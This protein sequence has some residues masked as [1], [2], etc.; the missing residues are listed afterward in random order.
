[1]VKRIIGGL[2]LVVACGGLV[3]FSEEGAVL[4]VAFATSDI[5]DLHP[6]IAV[7]KGDRAIIHTMFNGL[8]RYKPGDISAGFEPDLAESWE[9][10]SDGKVWTFHLRKG[11]MF[12]PWTNPVTGV[13]HPPYELT[14]EDVVY[15]FQS[16]AD[17][18]R[19]AYAGEY[20]GLIFE[21]VGPYT[22][23]VLLPKP[24]SPTLIFPKVADYAGGLIISKKAAED[25]GDNYHIRPVGTGPFMF[26]EYKSKEKYVVVRNEQ[27]FRGV[28]KLAGVEFRFMP[29]ESSRKFGLMS[30]E[31]DVIVGASQPFIEEMRA[32]PGVVVDVYGPGHVTALFFN[33]TKKPLDDIRV[34]RAILYCLDRDEAR[35]TVGMDLTE[36]VYTLV[37]PVLPGG[38]TREELE[39][40]GQEDGKDYIY[41][42]DRNRAKE[43]LTEAGYPNG[44]TLDMYIT[45]RADY[46][47]YMPNIQAQLREIGIDLRLKVVEH[48][49]YHS[50]IR[51]DM[52]PIV[53]YNVWRPTADVFLTHF[54]HSD[55][56]V[57][58]GASPNINFSHIGGVDLDGDGV[59]DSVDDLI[60]R[61][62]EELDP[63]KQGELWKEAQLKANDWAVNWIG[64]I[65]K[66][67]VARNS[68]VDWGYDLKS[69]LVLF[70]QI[71]EMTSISK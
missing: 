40:R 4:K 26:K 61:A 42:T 2:L 68:Y 22:V 39:K 51:K 24:M 46:Q 16:A 69:T 36:K 17:P 15:S 66:F 41:D 1:M 20:A 43:L 45:E 67:V 65:E 19:S 58:T 44:F 32:V 55:S 70:P 54:Y 21:A 47:V 49:T 8:V 59:I 63:E 29:D 14:S 33:C 52:N 34:R 60:E 35:A 38:L 18:A 12:H 28:P 3:A 11:V 57:V 71:N 48:A 10:S 6:H 62:R 56:I 23:R 7:A 13:Y 30:K 9:V 53:A 27:Y 25:L 37:P 5:S 64:F 50:Y 31:L